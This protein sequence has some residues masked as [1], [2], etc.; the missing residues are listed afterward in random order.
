MANVRNYGPAFK[1]S[2]TIPGAPTPNTAIFWTPAN[3]PLIWTG[4][5]W[6][7]PNGDSILLTEVGLAVR[8][9]A[10]HVAG[11]AVPLD[12][13]AHER[14]VGV[15]VAVSGGYALLRRRG[16][17]YGFAGLV[18]D[19]RYHAG[20]PAGSIVAAP[21]APALQKLIHVGA[22]LDA[23]VLLVDVTRPVRI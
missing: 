19:V 20:L 15:T 12:P 6:L 5:Q 8:Q 23:N 17:V 4:S 14:C 16:L 9:A 2:A 1:P 3:E 22:A 21:A 11:N 7:S 10:A 13:T 18:A